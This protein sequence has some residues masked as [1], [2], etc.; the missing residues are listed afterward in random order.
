[1]IT[2]DPSGENAIA[3]MGSMWEISKRSARVVKS[4][5]LMEL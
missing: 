5:A 3:E 4:I 2:L 1:M